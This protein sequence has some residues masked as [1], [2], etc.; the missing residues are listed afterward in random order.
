M[1]KNMGVLLGRMLEVRSDAGRA[2]I[3]HCIHIRAQVDIF[4]PLVRWTNANIYR[5]PCRIMF[6][7]K[8][9]A[10]FVISVDDWIIWIRI[11]STLN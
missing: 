11:S 8:K 1:K 7:Y 4:K 10:D 9:L 2:A 3:G 5:T 6:R